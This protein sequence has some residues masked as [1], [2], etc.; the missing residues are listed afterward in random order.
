MIRIRRGSGHP[1]FGTA[2]LD[3]GR[4]RLI[5]CARHPG[6]ER[7]LDHP[8]KWMIVWRRKLPE[9]DPTTKGQWK[10]LPDLKQDLEFDWRGRREPIVERA[11]ENKPEKVRLLEAFAPIACF[12]CAHP[13]APEARKEIVEIIRAIRHCEPLPR[14]PDIEGDLP[15]NCCHRK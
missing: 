4:L 15:V 5:W 11:D 1:T 2:W 13:N 7:T 6:G 3:I 8:N 9:F 14:P 10:T 12:E